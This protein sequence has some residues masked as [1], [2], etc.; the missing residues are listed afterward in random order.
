MS[1]NTKHLLPS[2]QLT[3]G[4]K[5]LMQDFVT[6]HNCYIFWIWK[7][8]QD[9]DTDSPIY[10]CRFK[11][12]SPLIEKKAYCNLSQTIHKQTSGSAV[13]FFLVYMWLAFICNWSFKTIWIATWLHEQNKTMTPFNLKFDDNVTRFWE[14]LFTTSLWFN[15]VSAAMRKIIKF[16]ERNK[17]I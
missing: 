13:Y 14:G 9:S 10:R 1:P 2:D 8:N 16:A 3:N 12:V 6:H 17:I 4:G 11:I 7:R 15:V 5:W